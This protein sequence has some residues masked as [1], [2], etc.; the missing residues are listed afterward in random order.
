[1]YELDAAS[2]PFACLCLYHALEQKRKALNPIPPPPAYAEL[3]L[4]I[5]VSSDDET[6]IKDVEDLTKT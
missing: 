4:P 2:D 3:N 5:L 1:L 6:K